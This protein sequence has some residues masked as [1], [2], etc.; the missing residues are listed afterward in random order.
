MTPR[1]AARLGIAGPA[2]FLIVSFAM[3]ALRPA[4]IHH[5]GWVSWPSVLA[6]GGPPD[7]LP[8]LLVFVWLGACYVVF[9][10]WGLRP[11]VGSAVATGAFYLVAA[12][13]ALLAFP[14]DTSGRA[15]WHGTLHL[16]GVLVS[17]VGLVVAVVAI[18]LATR[19]RPR[20]RA[21]RAVAWV[22]LL[23]ALIGLLGG[24]ETGWAKVAYVVGIT[25]PVVVL[26][27][28]VS[29]AGEAVTGARSG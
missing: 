12:G 6:T 22:P 26:A 13:D 18:T 16:A 15:S 1:A 2:G 14:T 17:T 19:G 23:A 11:V 20:F 10:R 4:L 29:R 3:A 7:A 21:W 25:A 24:F 5:H 8:Q 28:C 27:L 9:A